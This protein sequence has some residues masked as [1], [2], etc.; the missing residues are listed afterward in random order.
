[1]AEP[2]TSLTFQELYLAVGDI[3]YMTRSLTSDQT[4]VCKRI[5]NEAVDRMNGERDWTYLRPHA[6]FT[7]WATVTGT[8]SGS[9]SYA[10]PVSTITATAAKFFQ[11]MEG[12][13]FTF[14]TSGTEYTV[15]E[16]VS[17][18]EIKVTGDASGETADDT[19]T[20]TADGYYRMP[21]NFTGAMD[22]PTS[23]TDSGVSSLLSTTPGTIRDLYAVGSSGTAEPSEYALEPATFVAADGDRWDMLVWPIPSSTRTWHTRF[24]L[25]PDDMSADAA[26]PMG[27]RLHGHT[28]RMACYAQIE[29]EKGQSDGPFERKY[30]GSDD[31][32]Y[33]DGHPGGALGK[34]FRTDDRFRADSLGI[35]YGGN[36]V[37]RR[38]YE[39]DLLDTTSER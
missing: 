5:V 35:D 18:T 24:I 26:H 13:T 27:G 38:A 33:D 39:Y 2:T 17:T 31:R 32:A 3:L 1:M 10:S 6:S 15:A 23:S 14:D 25:T 9:P 30:R 8:V 36:R 7:L 4:T 21:H 11:S 20:M 16:Y 28:I 19:F 29:I 22:R 37:A 34:S 12:R